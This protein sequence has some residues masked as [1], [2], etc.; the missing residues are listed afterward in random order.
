VAGLEKPS[1]LEKVLGFKVLR[2]LKV[3]LGFRRPDKKYDPGRTSYRDSIQKNVMLYG[4]RD[5]KTQKITIK[6]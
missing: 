3:F 1:F 5:V 2:F 6:I 4:R